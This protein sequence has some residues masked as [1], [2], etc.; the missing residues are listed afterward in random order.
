MRGDEGRSVRRET[1]SISMSVKGCVMGGVV[2]CVVVVL[3]G[4]GIDVTS[5][6]PQSPLPSPSPPDTTTTPFHQ[7]GGREGG[8][9]GVG[10]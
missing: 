1:V 2:E 10:D 8:R 6:P 3:C 9:E 5:P 7:P 4:G